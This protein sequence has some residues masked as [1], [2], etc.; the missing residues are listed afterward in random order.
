M[1]HVLKALPKGHKF[2]A[3]YYI[4]DILVAI[5]DWR[6]QTGDHGRT[7]CEWILI[8]LGSTP[9][10]CQPMLSKGSIFTAANAWEQEPVRPPRGSLHRLCLPPDDF[11]TLR[12]PARHSGYP[13]P[14]HCWSRRREIGKNCQNKSIRVIC[15]FLPSVSKIWRLDFLESPRHGATRI[16]GISPILVRSYYNFVA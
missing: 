9:R 16:E 2:N 11:K 1:F 5:S 8:M 13:G 4:N 10:K 7:S 12:Q 15:V 3:Q 14:L 6:R